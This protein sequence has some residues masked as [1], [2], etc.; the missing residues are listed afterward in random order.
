MKK[1]LERKEVIIDP[2]CKHVSTTV[3]QNSIDIEGK[4]HAFRVYCYDCFSFLPE[5]D[6]QTETVISEFLKDKK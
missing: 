5:H 2:P 4:L 3:L 1:L 6:K